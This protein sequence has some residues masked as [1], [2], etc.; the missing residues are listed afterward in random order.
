M[1]SSNFAF[2]VIR[3]VA[4]GLALHLVYTWAT[5]LLS[6]VPAVEGVATSAKTTRLMEVQHD[7]FVR[8]SLITFSSAVLLYFSASVLTNLVAADDEAV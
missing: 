6:T 2:T 3:L 1:T 8:S 7:A 4:V 5:Y